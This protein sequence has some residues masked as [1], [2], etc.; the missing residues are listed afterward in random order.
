[1]FA[2]ELSFLNYRQHLVNFMLLEI[3]TLELLIQ[4]LKCFKVTKSLFKMS[5][6]SSPFL[7]LQHEG[8]VAILQT[9]SDFNTTG[10]PPERFYRQ[11]VLSLCEISDSLP[12]AKERFELSLPILGLW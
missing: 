5:L 6:M 9:E 2:T 4:P 1:M 7:H 8:S 12:V 3:R 10:R 11:S